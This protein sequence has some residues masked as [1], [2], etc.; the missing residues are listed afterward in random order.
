MIDE[1]QENLKELFETFLTAEEAA[2]AVED[3]QRAE[4]ILQLYPAPKP[5]KELVAGIKS[6]IAAR[7]LDKQANVFGRIVY[8]V[9]AVAAAVIIVTAIGLNLLEKDG[10]SK[11]LMYASIIPRVIWESDNIAADDTELAILTVD[12][13][14][15]EA[16]VAA[17]QSGENGTNGDRV[18]EE[19]EMELIAVNSDF[20][21]G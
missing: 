14:Q 1:T 20:W 7:L 12:I 11:K 6:E 4:Q 10:G 17:L 13:Q 21:K 2:K 19:I 18:A 3:V 5:D 15:I 9:A 16:E 8:R